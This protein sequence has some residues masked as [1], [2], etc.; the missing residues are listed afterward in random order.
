[1]VDR[2][3][4]WLMS[5]TWAYEVEYCKCTFS[6][7]PLTCIAPFLCSC[8]HFLC[9]SPFSCWYCSCAFI[10]SSVPHILTVPSSLAEASMSWW[11]GFHDTQ[12]TGLEWPFSTMM[13]VSLRWCHTYM[14]WSVKWFNCQ[15]TLYGCHVRLSFACMYLIL[16]ST[17][18]V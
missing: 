12:L 4:G 15:S 8:E 14:W 18:Y 5:M 11:A 9:C 3:G 10:C 1:M 6:T 7:D 13:G 16:Y 17:F 2:F